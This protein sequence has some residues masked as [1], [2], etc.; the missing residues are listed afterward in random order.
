MQLLRPF[1]TI[2]LLTHI[3][4]GRNEKGTAAAAAEHACILYYKNVLLVTLKIKKLRIK[5]IFFLPA[6]KRDILSPAT[7]YHLYLPLVLVCYLYLSP[8]FSRTLFKRLT[9]EGIVINLLN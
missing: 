9:D 1:T 4:V 7:D 2:C 6:A 3:R 8:V 5:I